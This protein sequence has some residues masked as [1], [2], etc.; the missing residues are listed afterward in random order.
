MAAELAVDAPVIFRGLLDLI[1]Q[2][3]LHLPDVEITNPAR[4]IDF[5]RWLGA[6][7]RAHGLPPGVYQ[8]V[9][10]ESLREAQLASL[11][12]NVLAS[13]VMDFAKAFACLT[14]T[15]TPQALFKAL[16]EAASVGTSYSDE[17]PRNPI[18]LSK[19]LNGLKASL[20][21]QGV[22]VQFGRGKERT[23]TITNN[24]YTA[25][26]QENSDVSF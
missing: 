8:G 9:Y 24:E 25:N 22:I 16:Y 20:E 23:I 19:R 15:G 10:A 4:M 11:Q 2:C 13:A 21:G 7:E 14:W 12:E 1:A 17:W 3:F 18:A 6:M 26:A 5:V